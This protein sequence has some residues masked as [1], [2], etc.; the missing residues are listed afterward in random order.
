[1]F[2]ITD[3]NCERVIEHLEIINWKDKKQPFEETMPALQ[4][5]VQRGLEIKQNPSNLICVHCSAGIGRTGTYIA[6]LTMIESLKY[7]MQVLKQPP[8][9]SIFGTIRR[10]R[11]QRYNMVSEV[12]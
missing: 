1:M 5:A 3:G 7:Q 9:I 8:E 12:V 4:Y 6:I 10:L 2:T 11:E